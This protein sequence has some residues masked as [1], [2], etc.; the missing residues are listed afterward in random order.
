MSSLSGAHFPH[1][2]TPLGHHRAL[3]WAPCVIY[4]SFPLA[5]YFIHGSVHVSTLRLQCGGPGFNPWVGKVCWRRERLP[6]PVFWPGEFQGLYIPWGRKRVGHDW[7]TLGLRA[8][9]SA[10]STGP[11]YT[12]ASPSLPSNRF[13]STIFLDS[14]ICVNIWYLF[15]SFG[16]TSLC[17]TGFRFIHLSSMDSNL[18]LFMGE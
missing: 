17:I 10:V 7:A 5:I 8:P 9:S 2:P 12:C 13:I 6:T 4:C 11:F 14:N 1:N 3:S 15:F 16:L 18:F